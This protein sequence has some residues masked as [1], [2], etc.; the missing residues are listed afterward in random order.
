MKDPTRN[1]ESVSQPR[2]TMIHHHH[3]LELVANGFLNI[4]ELV[5]FMAINVWQTRELWTTNPNATYAG[6]MHGI[7]SIEARTQPT[8]KVRMGLVGN[9]R[10]MMPWDGRACQIRTLTARSVWCAQLLVD[11]EI[12][13]PIA[14]TS[15]R[16]HTFVC[17]FQ[18]GLEVKEVIVIFWTVVPDLLLNSTSGRRRQK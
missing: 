15:S 14:F 7:R 13:Q 16:Q 10:W 12:P 6:T 3:L 17:L 11:R 2:I 5:A 18:G 8:T 9:L 1:L 4:L